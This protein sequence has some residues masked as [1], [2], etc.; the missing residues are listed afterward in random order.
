M[1][2]IIFLRK[3]YISLNETISDLAHGVSN[4]IS[5]L[6]SII[7]ELMTIWDLFMVEIIICFISVI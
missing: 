6:A 7:A 1:P 2:N 3:I 4:F 5:Q